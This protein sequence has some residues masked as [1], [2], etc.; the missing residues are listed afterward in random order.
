MAKVNIEDA[1]ANDTVGQEFEANYISGTTDKELELSRKLMSKL[2]NKYGSRSALE[3]DE[4]DWAKYKEASYVVYSRS[5]DRMDAAIKA[6]EDLIKRKNLLSKF[7]EENPDIL[8]GL[9]EW[10]RINL[11]KYTDY[12]LLFDQEYL[13]DLLKEL[14]KDGTIA[15]LANVANY[16]YNDTGFLGGVREDYDALRR[17]E[18]RSIYHRPV[19]KSHKT[20]RPSCSEGCGCGKE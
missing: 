9:S 18:V 5:K 3:A 14:G 12:G 1:I 15:H 11:R 2:L 17:G 13:W 7:F 19:C 4:K 20:V 10:Q 16:I 6:R 8:F